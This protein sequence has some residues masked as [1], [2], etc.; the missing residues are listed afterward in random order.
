ME[1]GIGFLVLL[2]LVGINERE[3]FDEKIKWEKLGYGYWEQIECRAPDTNAKSMPITTPIGNQ[4]VCYKQ[5]K[6]PE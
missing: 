1:L 6:R 5:T 2:S 4:Y 3:F